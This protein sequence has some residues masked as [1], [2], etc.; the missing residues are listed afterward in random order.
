MDFALDPVARR[1]INV[2]PNTISWIG[3]ILA[4]VCGVIL[5]ASGL[6]GYDWLLLVGAV[7]VIVSGY[8]DALDGKVAKLSGKA[9][10]KGDYLDH[11]FD[12]YADV[13]MIGGVAFS[14]T[15]C[16][17]YLGML[18]IIGV[19]LTSYMGTQAQAIGAPRLYAGFLGRADRVVLAT[20]FPI[21]QY[22]L[23]QFGWGSFEIAG[24]DI[25]WMEIMM[26]WFAV[27]GNLTAI[28]RAV[29]TWRNLKKMHPDEPKKER[30]PEDADFK[31][32]CNPRDMPGTVAR[33]YG[34]HSEGYR[35]IF[36]GVLTT[37]VNYVAYVLLAWCGINPDICNVCSWIVSVTFAFVVN[38]L[39]VFES[40]RTD[41]RTVGR[42][43]LEFY[44]ARVLTLIVSV[45]LFYLMYDMLGVSY[46][47]H[48]FSENFLGLGDGFF[49]KIVGSIVEI[50]LNYFLSKYWVFRA[51]EERGGPWARPPS[52]WW[53]ATPTT[54][55]RWASL[56]TYPP[57]RG[58]SRARPWT[59]APTGS[60]T[61]QST[62][63]AGGRRSRRPM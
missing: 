9:G 44:G 53:T 55:P 21:I 17:P 34:A 51:R 19:L 48:L 57:R 62:R 33:L 25:C 22:V 39:Y 12:R 15:W 50:V 61:S 3:L 47:V 8:F 10:P 5:Y 29:I 1:L 41:A 28:Q 43:A 13:F 7:M 20:V 2:N 42:E 6:E 38:K 46:G 37:V 27:V 59:P 35:Y 32:G 14:A 18:A 60:S 49:T 40:R 52:C 31:I 63:S 4:L 11:V 54:R 24:I 26:L 36:F 23:M 45:V 58:R 56:P 16:N 30:R